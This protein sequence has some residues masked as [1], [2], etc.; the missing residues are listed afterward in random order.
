M[1]NYTEHIVS[2][3][4]LLLLAAYSRPIKYIPSICVKIEGHSKLTIDGGH[5]LYYFLIMLHC[6]QHILTVIGRRM[7]S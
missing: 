3:C 2:C 7:A 5:T 6:E 1:T 4:Q